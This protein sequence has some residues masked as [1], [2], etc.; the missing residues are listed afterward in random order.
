MTET[1]AA[2]SA[3]PAAPV[4]PAP[5][6]APAP[7]APA[8]APPVAPAAAAAPAPAAIAAVEES[9]L[10]GDAPAVAAPAAAPQTDAE[11]L[12]AAQ[13]LVKQAAAAADPNSGKAWLLTDGV[14]G[15]GEKPAWFRADKY[16]NV[17]EQA[18]AYTELEPRFGAFVGAP[19]DGKYDF[20][21]PEGVEVKM[22]HPLMTEFTKWA[23]SKQLSQD[24]YTE[25]LGMLVQYEAAHAPNI[26]EIKASLGENAETRIAAVAQWGKANLGDDGYKTL[27]SATSG[28]NADAVFKVLE[29]IIAKT[30][31][32]AMPKPGDDVPG[33]QVGGGL[34]AIQAAHGAKAANG[35]LR[36]NEEP[37]Y[38]LEIEKKYRDYYAS[39][40]Q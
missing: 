15:T 13:E 26:A 10:P 2:A 9:L 1:P 21:P 27:R 25:L 29:Q 34:A 5:A 35:K 12:A 4:A 37:A 39:I 24:G 14:M 18:K 3:A 40:G 7:A 20:K 23:T 32:R 22:D 28:K 33:A 6:P 16:K 38:R 11:K 19:K 31:Q 30:S 36:V 8:A 17:S